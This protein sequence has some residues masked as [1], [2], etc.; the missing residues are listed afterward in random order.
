MSSLIQR[1]YRWV[2]VHFAAAGLA[3]PMLAAAEIWVAPS[4]DDGAPG[5]QERPLA[6]IEMAQRHARELRRLADPSIAGGVKIILRGG[7]YQLTAPIQLR[8]EDSGTAD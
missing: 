5:T 4:G 1:S 8:V 7:V 3:L 2:G 6:T